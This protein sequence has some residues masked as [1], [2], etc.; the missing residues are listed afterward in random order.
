MTHTQEQRADA[1]RALVGHGP[2]VLQREGQLLVLGADAVALR[3]PCP[4]GEPGD[5]LVPR[6][7]RS[8]VDLVTGHAAEGFRSR[9]GERSGTIHKPRL[10]R[11][12]HCTVVSA[13][14]PVTARSAW[15]RLR[16]RASAS[17]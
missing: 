12:P 7:N 10:P 15:A 3:R 8:P 6:L 14:Q 4:R 5:K 9:A 2:M 13:S 1:E 16:V 17:A 11:Q